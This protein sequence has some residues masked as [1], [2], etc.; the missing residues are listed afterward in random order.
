MAPGMVQAQTISA[1]PEHLLVQVPGSSLDVTGIDWGPGASEHG[2]TLLAGLRVRVHQLP[3]NHK[4]S[5]HD[6]AVELQLGMPPQHTC[7]CVPAGRYIR[8]G[9]TRRR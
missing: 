4:A 9:C 6:S 7:L 5:S 3:S 8:H 2:Q 1:R